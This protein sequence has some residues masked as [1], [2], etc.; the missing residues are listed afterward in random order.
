MTFAADVLAACAQIGNAT[1]KTNVDAAADTFEAA[2]KAEV[3]TRVGRTETDAAYV[4]IQAAIV[5]ICQLVASELA[6]ST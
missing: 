3:V 5:E 1:A 4:A 2:I 6:D